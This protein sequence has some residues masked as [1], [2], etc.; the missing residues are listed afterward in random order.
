M[1]GNVKEKIVRVDDDRVEIDGK[2][3]YLAEKVGEDAFVVQGS[4]LVRH[5]H[6]IYLDKLSSGRIR[7]SVPE[8][9]DGNFLSYAKIL[10][11]W[12]ESSRDYQVYLGWQENNPSW[13]RKERMK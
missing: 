5:P 3:W 4:K 10:K 7:A 12:L 11:D 8:F 1:D 6:R 9:K 2:V 13:A